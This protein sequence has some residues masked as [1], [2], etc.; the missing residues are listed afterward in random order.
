SPVFDSARRL[1]IF[2]IEGGRPAERMATLLYSRDPV[3]K[4]RQV[5][6]FGVDLLI[7][8]AISWPLCIA[9]SSVGVEVRPCICGSIEAVIE[10]YCD[11]RLGQ[12]C[13]QMPG[14][15]SRE[16]LAFESGR[17]QKKASGKAGRDRSGAGRRSPAHK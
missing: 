6:R 7:C 5:A 15:G 1:W 8:G 10:A 4:A 3:D 11:N 16:A 2:S 14:T 13:F 12:E 17:K 9:L